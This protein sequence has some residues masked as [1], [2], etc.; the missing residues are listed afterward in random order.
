MCA[1][2]FPW[3]NNVNSLHLN[4]ITIFVSIETDTEVTGYSTE[5]GWKHVDRE[6][7]GKPGTASG[8]RKK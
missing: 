7:I 2:N 5:F 8:Q 3:I 1:S 4:N 6:V